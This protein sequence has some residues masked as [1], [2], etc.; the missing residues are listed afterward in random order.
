MSKTLTF[1][2]SDAA[3]HEFEIQMQKCV[4]SLEG[5]L[6]T[7][8]AQYL[9]HEFLLGIPE[10][11][12][13]HYN[14]DSCKKFIY[15]YG[16]LVT[17]NEDGQTFPALWPP[18]VPDFFFNAVH[19]IKEA[20]NKAKVT[21][22]FVNDEKVWG[23]QPKAT[24]PWTHLCG[25]PKFVFKDKLKTAHQVMAEKTQDFGILCHGLVDF[26]FEAA[27]Q[28]VRVLDADALDRSEKTLGV[29]KWF[30]AL[31]EKIK[32]IRGPRRS[33]LI[34][35][36]VATAPPGFC[37]IRSTMISTLLQDIVDG[38][39]FE[40]ISDRWEKKMHPTNYRRRK[41]APTDGQIAQ[42][43]KVFETLEAEKAL[44]RRFAKLEE[45][46]P[47]WMPKP[48]D[49][50]TGGIFDSLKKVGSGI[51]PLVLPETKMTWEKFRNEVL[52]DCREI[53]L[54]VPHGRK[55]PF[56]GMVTA[57]HPDAPP[58]IQ[59]DND[60]R[61]PFSWYFYEGISAPIMWNVPSDTWVEV[62]AICDSP[63]HWYSD[64][65]K[66]FP[67]N[68]L[69]ILSGCRPTDERPGGG[70]F[71]EI[72]R[73][74]YRETE[75]VL[76]AFFQKQLISGRTEG[77]ANGWAIQKGNVCQTRLKVKTKLGEA[78]YLIDRWN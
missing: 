10:E 8:D 28:A 33:N 5:P 26:S 31:H 15:K 71:N 74:E 51:S 41:A 70:M 78:K 35:H 27:Q 25:I 40:E 38:L 6:F 50:P 55:L 69:L 62:K 21:G 1:V 75:S 16:G 72:L 42:A 44:G 57:E 53:S 77:T 3:Y 14:C 17:I 37:H 65:F 24:S 61:N 73:S 30:L 29:A 12:R 54:Y 63:P 68:A 66:H 19:R 52:K 23:T 45:I 4:N 64:K 67:E 39:S 48:I 22:V 46:F 76:E 18:I 11:Q 56:F 43:N 59:W 60:P 13:Q 36:A 7:T 32:T 49:I 2:A 20:V 9:D 47:Y 58:I 34:W